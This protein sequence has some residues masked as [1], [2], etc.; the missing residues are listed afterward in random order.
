MNPEEA[1]QFQ[2]TDERHSDVAGHLWTLRR[3]AAGCR[4]LVEMGTDDGSTT[5]AFLMGRPERVDSYD[6]W[7]QPRIKQIE[8]WAKELGV[9]YEMHVADSRVLDCPETDMLYLDTDHRASTLAI[10]LERHAPK[11]RKYIAMHDTATCG[12]TSCGE[13]EE[14]YD[15]WDGPGLWQ[16]IGA[17]LR[18]HDEWRITYLTHECCGLTILQRR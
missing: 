14:G 3:Y 6:L 4:N 18:A 2:L 13:T 11:V 16:S 17:F 10:E 5:L 8:A 15:T 9:E 12:D 1:F 7:R